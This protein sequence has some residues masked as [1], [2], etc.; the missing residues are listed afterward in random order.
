MAGKLRRLF[1]KIQSSEEVSSK[2]LGEINNTKRNEVGDV[3]FQLMNTVNAYDSYAQDL[4]LEWP[5][6][7]SFLKR[8]QNEK[9]RLPHFD[10]YLE[11]VRME[12]QGLLMYHKMPEV[13]E[14]LIAAADEELNDEIREVLR[15][16]INQ[17]DV[18]VIWL[19]QM[20]APDYS[21]YDLDPYE[22]VPHLATLLAY[23]ESPFRLPPSLLDH[24]L[25]LARSKLMGAAWRWITVLEHLGVRD[26]E[27]TKRS[28]RILQK[29][30]AGRKEQVLAIYK[31]KSKDSP[32]WKDL[33][34][35]R[36]A[37][38]IGKEMDSA[39]STIRKYLVELRKDG[40][41]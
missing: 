38:T 20:V 24:R 37:D 35:S 30:K 19:N 29:G 1:E 18:G 8:I 13:F 7:K 40:L 25:D 6:F 10:N 2:D 26:I 16:G 32:R 31:E 22:L 14:R 33:S 5:P 34:D 28:T 15:Y 11:H 3:L 17:H 12:I 41:I 21:P 9:T 27:R 4:S 36:R 23:Y 39:K